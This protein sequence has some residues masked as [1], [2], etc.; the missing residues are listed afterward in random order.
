MIALMLLVTFFVMY[1]PTWAG[2]CQSGAANNAV[3]V[4]A[5]P[6]NADPSGETDSTLA[7]NAATQA[8]CGPTGN[9]LHKTVCIG[10][11]NY[12]LNGMWNLNGLVNCDIEGQGAGGGSGPDIT[13]I[14]LRG[15]WGI[16]LVGTARYQINGITFNCFNFGCAFLAKCDGTTNCPD[17]GSPENGLF[18]TFKDD[19]WNLKGQNSYG[20]YDFGGE[21]LVFS[22]NQ[23]NQGASGGPLMVFTSTSSAGYTT[24]P[25]GENLRTANSDPKITTT[26]IVIADSSFG[27]AKGVGIL[28]DQGNNVVQGPSTLQNYVIREP[29][30]HLGGQYTA[31]IGDQGGT[32][33]LQSIHI[34]NVQVENVCPTCTAENPSNAEVVHFNNPGGLYDFALTGNFSMVTGVHCAT[35]TIGLSPASSVVYISGYGDPQHICRGQCVPYVTGLTFGTMVNDNFFVSPVVFPGLACS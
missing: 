23:F 22:L 4:D 5:P 2:L 17:N 28:F 14:N 19:T 35:P 30:V 34:E 1:T 32:N 26:H 27:I 11:G 24:G 20:I 21:Q 10:A 9:A 31:F 13:V 7:F 33:Y 25:S 3:W 6:Y 15:P 12:V 8:A 29:Y 18:G 16:D